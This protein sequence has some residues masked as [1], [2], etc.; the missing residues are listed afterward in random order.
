M[1]KESVDCRFGQKRERKGRD[2][3]GRGGVKAEYIM[4]RD[5]SGRREEKCS[6]VGEC[7]RGRYR[8]GR[9]PKEDRNFTPVPSVLSSLL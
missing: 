8:S 5:S 9:R 6:T 2:G 4:G 7:G 1:G 3:E